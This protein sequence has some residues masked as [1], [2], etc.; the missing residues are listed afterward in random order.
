[1]NPIRNLKPRVQ[2]KIAAKERKLRSDSKIARLPTAQR[3]QI[4]RWFQENL[5]Y[6]EIAQRAQREFGVKITLPGL[7][8]YYARL[9]GRER[10][11][12][13]YH[14]KIGSLTC[15]QR[16]QI[17]QWFRQYLSY[18]QIADRAQRDLGVHIS[19]GSLCAF[20]ALHQSEIFGPLIV[21]EAALK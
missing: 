6:S 13:T 5:L 14:S 19:T 21:P 2:G 16:E 17:R 9:Y 7:S 8:E 10:K 20:Y 12:R 4:H 3:E 11:P 18:E 15:E 1:M